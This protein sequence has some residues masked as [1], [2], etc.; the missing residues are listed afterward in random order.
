MVNVT[1]SVSPIF[2]T[3]LTSYDAGKDLFCSVNLEQGT[4]I[5]ITRSEKWRVCLGVAGDKKNVLLG[6]DSQVVPPHSPP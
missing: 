2:V 5:M 4:P 1:V 3:I 6:T